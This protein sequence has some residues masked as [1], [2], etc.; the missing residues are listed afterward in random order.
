MKPAYLNFILFIAF[1]YSL[2]LVCNQFFF[3]SLSYDESLF[4]NA[5]IAKDPITFIDKHWRGFPI[6]SMDYIGALK[7]WLYMPIFK[8]FGVNLLSIRLPVVMLMYFNFFL[9]Y[10]IAQKYF[11]KVIAILLI[12]LLFTDYTLIYQHKIDHGPTAIETCLKLLAIYYI[13]RQ[14]SLKN[15]FLILGILLLGVF[16]K[17]NFIWFANALFGTYIL[18]IFLFKRENTNYFASFFNKKIIINGILYL[19]VLSFF[20]VIVKWQNIIPKTIK[21]LSELFEVVEYQFNHMLFVILNLRYEY[22]VGWNSDYPTL[23]ISGKIIL[24]TVILINIFWLLFNRK[25]IQKAHI[26]LFILTSLIAAQLFITKEAS[27]IWHVLMLYPF[28][29]LLILNT[30]YIGFRFIFQKKNTLYFYIF[31]TVWITNNLITYQ[32]FQKKIETNC[33]FWLYDPTLNK[34]IDFTQ[35]QPEKNIVSL[36]AGIH[37]QLLVLDKKNKNYKEFIASEG[38]FETEQ[39]ESLILKP[40]EFI[41][42][43]NINSNLDTKRIHFR[44]LDTALKIN[45]LKMNQIHNIKDNCGT[46]QYNI[47]K[48]KKVLN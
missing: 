7:S 47:F 9:I 45:N 31:C 19:F 33:N 37:S 26:Q 2:Y 14:E 8:I 24:L 4:I 10:K 35:N 22:L 48:I 5:A 1:C 40:N 3:F 17:L 13:T 32:I 6:M 15:N 21:S 23:F 28:I 46:V 43:E 42:V 16:N 30:I 11:E 20:L 29:Q 41:I 25:N 36:G 12:I 39:I 34:L 18:S 38:N 44:K 27:N